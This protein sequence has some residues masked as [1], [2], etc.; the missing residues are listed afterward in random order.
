MLQWRYRV[1][2]NARHVV[3]GH[4]NDCDL[5]NQSCGRDRLHRCRYATVLTRR[6]INESSSLN[7]RCKFRFAATRI[8]PWICRS[9]LMR[10]TNLHSMR[11]WK[12]EEYLA[13]IRST[14]LTRYC[15]LPQSLHL[16]RG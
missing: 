11:R 3:S 8:W 14:S 10:S 6:G 7:A 16:D 4:R 13:F 15:E 2:K 5:G 9:D 1:P 12:P